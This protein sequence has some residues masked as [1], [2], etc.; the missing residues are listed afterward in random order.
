[1][2]HP[3]CRECGWRKGGRDSWNGFACKC[4]HSE[5]ALTLVVPS[6]SDKWADRLARDAVK[7]AERIES[8]GATRKR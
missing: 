8:A 2:I 7:S 4:G 3:Y 6:T 5:P 1:M